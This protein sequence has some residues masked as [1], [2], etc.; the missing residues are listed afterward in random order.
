MP[1][2]FFRTSSTLQLFILIMMLVVKTASAEDYIYYYRQVA[3]AEK[4]I[5]HN[6]YQ[7]ALKIYENVFMQYSYNNPNDCY[8]A[9]QVAAYICDTSA[10]ISYMRRGLS[11]GLPIQTI[12]GNPH[13]VRILQKN[14]LWSN[15]SVIDSC[16][17]N[18]LQKINSEAR[19][20]VLSL[21]AYDQSIVRRLKP[22]ELYNPGS[23]ILK[24]EYKPIWDSLFQEVLNLTERVG[25]PAQ[26]VIGTQNGEDGLFAAS[27]HSLY[28]YYILIHH[29]KVWPQIKALLTSELVKGNITP[30]MY[31]AI[32]DNANGFSDYEYM[33]YFALRPCGTSA[34]R[35]EID[36]RKS[37]INTDRAAIG[38]CSYEV[39]QLKLSSTLAYRKMKKTIDHSLKPYFDFQPDLHFTGE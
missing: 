28:V 26:K 11:F 15:P 1:V 9:A 19:V 35:K 29:R 24:A 38:L 5:V 12:A 21:I 4:A 20:K 14:A 22:G 17:N 31:G 27:P 18:Y 37:Q 16:V 30:Q 36:R 23:L 25:F 8:V 13:L 6:R 32:A 2:I 34:C 7:E 10:C 33:R 3:E 39:M